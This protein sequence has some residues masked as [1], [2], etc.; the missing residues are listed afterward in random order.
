MLAESVRADAPR[1]VSTGAIWA[2]RITVFGLSCGCK[3]LRF[4]SPVG[5]PWTLNLFAI[6]AAL[7]LQREIA[8]RQRV[9]PSRL[10]EWAGLSSYS[11]Y[12]L[13]VPAGVLFSR[14]FAPAHSAFGWVVM[15]LFVLGASYVFYFIVERPGHTLARKAAQRFRPSTAPLNS[16]NAA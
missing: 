16:T 9:A 5:Y 2:W 10:L 13:H 14:L 11:L 8:F 15:F 4:H 1:H 7:W 12:L 3:V 6:V